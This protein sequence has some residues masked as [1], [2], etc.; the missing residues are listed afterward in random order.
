[1]KG[2]RPERLPLAPLLRPQ[3]IEALAMVSEELLSP[4][5]SYAL[6]QIDRL[7]E[8]GVE[9][10]GGGRIEAPLA[11]RLA[12][13]ARR[14]AFVVCGLDEA[15]G[16]RVSE[17]M[18]ARKPRLAMALDAIG[19][20]ALFRL[21]DWLRARLKRK[22]R[23]LGWQVGGPMEPGMMGFGIGQQPKLLS[24]SGAS[25]LGFSIT[26]G[27][28]IAPG[29]ALGFAVGL[30]PNLPEWDPKLRCQCCP[31]QEICAHKAGCK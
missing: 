8:T 10:A 31:S 26:D 12:K 3:A 23:E 7:D 27:G 28:M 6:W 22:A 21:S 15:F 29:R 1:L 13:G 24:L 14:I 5:A 9:L 2:L 18:A 20:V 16:Q 4:R 17:V 19:T 30:G 25:G 11:Y